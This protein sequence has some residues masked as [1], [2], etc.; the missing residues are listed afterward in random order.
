MPTIYILQNHD[1]L[2]DEDNHIVGVYS[3]L[4][5]AKKWQSILL[6]NPAYEDSHPRITQYHIDEPSIDF[7]YMI[8]HYYPKDDAANFYCDYFSCLDQY[9]S[10]MDCF[11]CATPFNENLLNKDKLVTYAREQ[12]KKWKESFK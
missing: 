4:E 3:T 7:K 10:K 8:I 11:I 1:Y 2:A 5:E 9:V 12:Y 6:A